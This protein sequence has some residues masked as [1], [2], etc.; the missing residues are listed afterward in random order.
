MKMIDE[1]DKLLDLT[2]KEFS[3]IM[4][5]KLEAQRFP[6]KEELDEID[7]KN[8]IEYLKKEAEI[9]RV[10]KELEEH[11]KKIIDAI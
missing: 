11:W 9:K 8:K 5:R 6:L 1:K 2:G 10:K 7:R 4:E 3:K